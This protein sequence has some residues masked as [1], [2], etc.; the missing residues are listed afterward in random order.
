[1]YKCIDTTFLQSAYDVCNLLPSIK[2][3]NRYAC[4]RSTRRH[5]EHG[6]KYIFAPPNP[7]LPP[8]PLE[9][10]LLLH[11]DILCR[12]PDN[13]YPWGNIVNASTGSFKGPEKV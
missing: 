8:P 7:S 1:M 13:Y 2:L 9:R 12:Y 3:A 5:I 11:T 10:S 4:Q 6:E